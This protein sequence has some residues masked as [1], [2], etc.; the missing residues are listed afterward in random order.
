VSHYEPNTEDEDRTGSY[1]FDDQ[2]PSEPGDPRLD[3]REFELWVAAGIAD[4]E[5]LLATHAAF[6]DWRDTMR[7]RYGSPDG[8]EPA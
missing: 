4:L 2:G 3:V 8:G 6:D 7:R 5:E 1:P